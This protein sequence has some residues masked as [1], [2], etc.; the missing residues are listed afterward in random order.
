MRAKKREERLKGWKDE[1]NADEEGPNF[2]SQSNR[3]SCD[4]RIHR[5]NGRT[6]EIGKFG[7]I[8]RFAKKRKIFGDG[9]QTR[10]G[11]I[12]WNTGEQTPVG[13]T[14]K[15]DR[16]PEAEKEAVTSERVQTLFLLRHFFFNIL[17]TGSASS[18]F[19]LAQ[20]KPEERAPVPLAIHH[21]P[22]C[23]TFAYF[24]G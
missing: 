1:K 19:F 6:S 23:V 4:T 18:F 13:I 8:S 14:G 7:K 16:Q 5:T 10:S 3:D 9:E 2:W 24:E 17:T 21:T 12:G 15:N 22:L 11:K 20:H